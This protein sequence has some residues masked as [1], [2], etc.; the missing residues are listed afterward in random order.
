RRRCIL[1]TSERTNQHGG[2][3]PRAKDPTHGR[4]VRREERRRTR[5]A[6][7]GVM[8]CEAA[9]ARPIARV[10]RLF[11]RW[12][13]FFRKG[14]DPHGGHARAERYVYGAAGVWQVAD[15][16]ALVRVEG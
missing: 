11:G 4:S 3:R 16:D 13:Q 5:T 6:G 15:K 9:S 12:R 14:H 7:R 8:G 2:P 1:A 10:P